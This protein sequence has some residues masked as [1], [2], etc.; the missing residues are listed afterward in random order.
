MTVKQT[1]YGLVAGIHAL[2]GGNRRLE[3]T[4]RLDLGELEKLVQAVDDLVRDIRAAC[5]FEHGPTC[6]FGVAEN[7]VLGADKFQI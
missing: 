5:V 6:G 7:R 1:S 3:E 4:V 2:A